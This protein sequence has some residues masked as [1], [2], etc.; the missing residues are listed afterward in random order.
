MIL[1]SDLKLP[2]VGSIERLGIIETPA[3]VELETVDL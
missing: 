3:E 1:L 2:L